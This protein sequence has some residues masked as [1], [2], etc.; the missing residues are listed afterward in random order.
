MGLR[1]GNVGRMWDWGG[2]VGEGDVGLGR[3]G[4]PGD[5]GLVDVGRCGAECVGLGVWGDVGLRDVGL[6]VWG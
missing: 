4:G 5:V 1:W 2:G 6:N 3:Y